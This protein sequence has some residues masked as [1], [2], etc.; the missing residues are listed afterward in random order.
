MQSGVSVAARRSTSIG[1]LVLSTAIC[2]LLPLRVSGQSLPREKTY[3]ITSTQ[4]QRLGETYGKIAGSQVASGFFGLYATV[5][6][7]EGA[8][9]SKKHALALVKRFR[10]DANTTLSELRTI[11]ATLG[12]PGPD[13]YP[14]L[15]NCIRSLIKQADLFR[16]YV[17]TADAR[18]LSS[19][20]AEYN[21]FITLLSKL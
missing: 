17:A 16:N 13:F 2:L 21:N 8:A 11:P 9:I 3:S 12:E 5:E 15:E 19:Y 7:Y 1:A 20:R 4:A 14:E 10:E 6:G 18:S